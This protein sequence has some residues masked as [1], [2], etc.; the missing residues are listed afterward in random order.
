VVELAFR[1]TVS[2]ESWTRAGHLA[3]KI[4]RKHAR[5]LMVVGLAFVPR[6][7]LRIFHRDEPDSSHRSLLGLNSPYCELVVGWVN[8]INCIAG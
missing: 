7:F 4:L 2:P 5:M 1:L 6:A 3:A 8:T